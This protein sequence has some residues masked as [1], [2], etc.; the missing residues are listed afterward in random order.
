MDG[1]E[2]GRS[3]W[4]TSASATW[5]KEEKKSMVFHPSK[6][7]IWWVSVNSWYD[8]NTAT[9]SY[10]S[11]IIYPASKNF[12]SCESPENDD[13]HCPSFSVRFLQA[14][15]AVL[16]VCATLHTLKRGFRNAALALEF[17]HTDW[18]SSSV[19]HNLV[20]KR[21]SPQYKHTTLLLSC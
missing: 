3:P 18:C 8:Y 12:T 7:G 1:K 6:Q 11:R 14:L 2:G 16:S 21:N 17:A 10:P 4:Q 9:Q 13:C 5:Q 19:I 15:E 20:I